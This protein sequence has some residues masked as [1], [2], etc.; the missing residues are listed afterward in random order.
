VVLDNGDVLCTFML[1][2]GLGINDFVTMQT[3]SRDGG[4]T[5]DE[6]RPVWP[7]LASRYSLFGSVSRAPSGELFLYGIRFPIDQAGESFWSDATQGM[8][9]NDLFW[10]RSRD[11]GQSWTDPAVVP[12]P[13][14]GSAEAPGPLLVS[15]TGR[16]LVC[17]APYNTFDPSVL[18][19]RNQIVVMYSDDEGQSW[20]HR[21]MLRF[22]E[23][24]SGGAE[25]WVIELAD[26]RL[27]GACWQVGYSKG[28]E[29]PNPY[30]LSVD[31]GETWTPPRSTGICG[32]SIALA[33][34]R[35]GRALLV[36]NQRKHGDPGVWLAVGR[37]SQEGFGMEA[38]RIVWRAERA[39]QHGSS[40]EHLEWEDFAFGEPSII[41]LPDGSVLVALW[42]LQP[43]GQG[44]RCVKLHP[45]A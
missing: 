45:N 34:L 27:L 35:D 17:Y 13:I 31:C 5:W 11:G 37:P 33:A 26:G 41:L 38:N 23:K 16:W 39:T 22:A 8:K 18:V 28:Q 29:F 9:Q 43:S 42:C 20:Q 2:S 32:Q 25:A 6:A 3:V 10:S 15:R 7:H 1:Q 19:D 30:A 40:A 12:M 4:L 14:A 21:S 36:Y 44:I 24:D